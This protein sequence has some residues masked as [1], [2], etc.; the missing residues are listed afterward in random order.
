[1]ECAA[2][3]RAMRRGELDRLEIPENP[4]D[5]LAQQIV[6]ICAAEDME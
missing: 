4:L 5:V 1:M 6:A 3:V 2:L